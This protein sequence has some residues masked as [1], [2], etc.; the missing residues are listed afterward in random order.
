MSGPLQERGNQHILASC[1]ASGKMDKSAAVSVSD[2]EGSGGRSHDSEV[3]K[4]LW[5]QAFVVI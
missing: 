5:C 3:L 1:T 2:S 4:N